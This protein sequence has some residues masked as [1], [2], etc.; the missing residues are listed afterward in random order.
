MAKYRTKPVTD[1]KR[2]RANIKKLHTGTKRSDE[3]RQKMSESSRSAEFLRNLYGFI[4]LG[5]TGRPVIKPRFMR[6]RGGAKV[7]IDMSKVGA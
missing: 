6:K 5:S 2:L 7:R 3:T 4:H 1:R